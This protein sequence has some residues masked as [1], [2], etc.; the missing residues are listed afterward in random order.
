M[1]TKPKQVELLSPAGSFLALKAVAEAGADAVYA[2]GEN[3]GARAY[4]KNLIEMELLSAIDYLHLRGKR[5]YLTVNTLLKRQELEQ[6]LY[7]YIAPLYRQGLDGVIVQDLGVLSFLREH[8]PEMNVHA[9]TQMSVSSAYGAKLLKELGVSRIVT[10][11]EISLN[12]IRTI[13]ED[14]DLEIESFVHGAMCYSYSGRCLLSS[15]LGG[16]SG[17]R[18]RCAQPCRLPYEFGKGLSPSL[19][20]ENGYSQYRENKQGKFGGKSV[21]PSV[22]Y[23]LSMKDLAAIELLPQLIQSGVSSLKIEGRMKQVEY[24]VGVTRIYRHY[25]D[26][27]PENNGGGYLV[28]EEDKRILEE[29]GSRGG[30]TK[31]Y[32]ERNS[33][34]GK[35]NEGRQEESMISLLDSSH[36]KG[37]GGEAFS[38]KQ[39]LKSKSRQ[40][41]M[42]FVQE[43]PSKKMS[44]QPTQSE[45]IAVRAKLF[46]RIGTAAKLTL[47]CKEKEV[48]VFGAVAEQAQNAPLVGS[49]LIK[50][51]QKTGETDYRIEQVELDIEESVFLAV[52][53]INELRREG[54]CALREALLKEY[55]R[56]EG[57]P[58]G[59]ENSANA[60]EDSIYEENKQSNQREGA[61]PEKYI[62]C[63]E[64][65]T[66]LSSNNEPIKNHPYLTAA[67]DKP[68]QLAPLLETGRISTIYVDHGICGK[69]VA[70]NIHE[71]GKRILY[72]LPQVFRQADVKKQE[73]RIQAAIEYGIDGFVVHTYDALEFVKE[74]I[75]TNSDAPKN[76]ELVTGNTLYCLTK[77]SYNT[78]LAAGVSRV[79]LP[80]ELSRTELKD[81]GFH[82]GEL[83]VYGHL[84]VV[85]SAQCLMKN[86]GQCIGQSTG[87]NTS[88][89][90]ND[91]RKAKFPVKICCEG[92]YNIIY[93]S[94]PLSLFHVLNKNSIGSLS[95]D[96]IHLSF[97]IEDENQVQQVLSYC[98]AGIFGEGIDKQNYLKE[99]TGS[100]FR[101][102][103]A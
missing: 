41:Q 86:T 68:E 17:N 64:Q 4:A 15:V 101:S 99:Y 28:D 42:G 24:A 67:I 70:E 55:R 48:T 91:R 96:S 37:Q 35:A 44:I 73:E 103:V 31:G 76:L 32:Y 54:I 46:L 19:V 89:F 97:T 29:L 9:S 47:F 30:F 53:A 79:S 45:K 14:T 57:L 16:R 1:K 40:Q 62:E 26:T 69:Q 72:S 82:G 7:A 11:R 12:E 56:A 80:V 21:S 10:A 51:L 78:F 6:K 23:P 58:Q 66:V 38:A 98:E 43:N 95:L 87:D 2:A 36:R 90:L 60:I 92:C 94:V 20:D 81:R 65:S 49:E 102:G 25:L 22:V 84:P 13:Y 52:S 18:G 8:F 27:Y 93:N 77:D 63:A 50:R 3:F 100:H 61:N 75:A 83:L 71:S 34:G 85:V 39:T 33:Y 5:F 88:Y 74:Q 59:E